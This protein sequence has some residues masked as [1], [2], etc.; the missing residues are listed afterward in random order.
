MLMLSSVLMMVLVST[1]IRHDFK[2]SISISIIY[3]EVTLA[4]IVS[5][6][7]TDTG[8]LVSCL[9]CLAGEATCQRH[10][11]ECQDHPGHGSHRVNNPS[12]VSRRCL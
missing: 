10:L 11:Q 8:P 4:M 2:Y 7:I 6:M 5:K 1:Y 9:T 12:Q 3:L